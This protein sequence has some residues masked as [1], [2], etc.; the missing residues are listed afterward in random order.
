MGAASDDLCEVTL[1]DP[2]PQSGGQGKL[3]GIAALPVL[4]SAAMAPESEAHVEGPVVALDPCPPWDI[5]TAMAY[6]YFPDGFSSPMGLDSR[7][8]ELGDRVQV[9]DAP[10]LL[11]GKPP[12]EVLICSYSTQVAVFDPSSMPADSPLASSPGTNYKIMLSMGA[13]SDDLCEVTVFDPLPGTGGQGALM[14]IAAL[15]VLDSAVVVP[16][17]EAHVEGRRLNAMF[18]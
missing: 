5:Q 8:K 14:G 16:E 15:P 2:L 1:F 6:K 9:K 18:V 13:D 3:V 11:L 7:I 17:S 4:D 10:T 12:A